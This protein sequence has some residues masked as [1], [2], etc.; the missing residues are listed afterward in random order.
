M[1]KYCYLNG[2]IVQFDKAKISIADI[3]LLRGFGVF[4][5]L[6]TYDG[7]PFLLEDHLRRFKNSAKKMGLSLP[8]KDSELKV[9]IKKLI[10]KNKEPN[11]GIRL[12]LTGGKSSDGLGWDKKT[13]TFFVL[14]KKIETPSMKMYENGVKLMTV[15]FQREFPEAKTNNYI[16]RIKYEPLLTKERAHEMLFIK[17]N[18]VL[19]GATCNVFIFKGDTLITPQ[20]NILLGT[21]RNLVLKLAR[22]MFKIEERELKTSELI[23]ADEVFITSTTRDIMPVS[24]IDEQKIGN[25]KPGLRTKKLTL[26]L[27]NYIN[28]ASNDE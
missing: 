14:L 9:I 22:E 4:D 5:Y 12:V 11:V 1:E 18:R 6:R 28:Q 25:G 10:D 3:G 15:N 24:K 17:D 8:I 7:K 27:K 19:E 2:K 26:I 16:T 23:E 13:P 21:R 20:K